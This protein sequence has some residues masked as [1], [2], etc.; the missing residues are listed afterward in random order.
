MNCKVILNDAMSIRIA[1]TSETVTP[2]PTDINSQG[3]CYG[4]EAT[5]LCMTLDRTYYQT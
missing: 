4:D 2:V 1:F 3:I 5:Y